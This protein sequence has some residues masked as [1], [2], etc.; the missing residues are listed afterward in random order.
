MR[1]KATA[2][3]RS[4]SDRASCNAHVGFG[5][6]HARRRARRRRAAAGV[7]HRTPVLT[8]RTLDA[9]DRRARCSSSARASS[10]AARSSSAA[11]TTTIS[12]LTPRSAARGVARLLVG[13]PRPGGG[14]RG[15]A[16][17]RAGDDPDAGRR[18]RGQGRR[19]ARLRRRGGHLRPLRPRTARQIGARAARSERGLTLVPPVRPSAVIAGQGTAALELLED[20]PASWTRC[21][22]GRR[23]RADRRLR[24]GRQGAA[25]GHPGDRRGA[26]RPATTRADRWRPAAG[27]HRRAAAP[28]PTASGEIAGRADL[29]GQPASWSTRSCWSRTP[30]SW[31]AMRFAFDRL[32]L[33]LGAE[34]GQRAG[35]AADRPGAAAGAAGGS[36][37]VGRQRR[38][39][40]VRPAAGGNGRAGHR[41][42]GTRPLPRALADC[43]DR[44]RRAPAPSPG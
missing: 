25:A 33:V 44:R 4:T 34:R 27:A 18:A 13:Q 5:H 37:A 11:P 31:P 9:R 23:R 40:P 6:D 39:R 28:S 19:H 21:G 26:A 14:A 24:H 12:Q 42:S 16:A 32:K 10:A 17:G 22:A 15:A 43:Q 1:S 8:S 36:G 7:A 41:L 3:C 38:S 20:E 30:R 29:R 35:G 2:S